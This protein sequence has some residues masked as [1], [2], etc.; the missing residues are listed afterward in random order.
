MPLP[1][2]CTFTRGPKLVK[3]AGVRSLLLA[4]TTMAPE[5]I[6]EAGVTIV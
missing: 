2:A 1:Q 6:V 4:P 5:S 3:H